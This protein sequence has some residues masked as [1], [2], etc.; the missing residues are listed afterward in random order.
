VTALLVVVIVTVALRPNGSLGI[1]AVAIGSALA[2]AILISGPVSGAG[3][4]P[5]RALGPM[6]PSGRFT[7]WW[8]YLIGPVLGASVAVVFVKHVILSSSA[9]K[10]A[11]VGVHSD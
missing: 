9:L 8:V 4:N 5:A 3:V 10:S 7:D 11:E 2:A 1:S 6:I